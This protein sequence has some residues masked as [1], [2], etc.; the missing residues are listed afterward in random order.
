MDPNDLAGYLQQGGGAMPASTEPP[1]QDMAAVLQRMMTPDP[2][3]EA[4]MGPQR[5]P[6]YP[7]FGQ[8]I[9]RM[10]RQYDQMPEGIPGPAPTGQTPV[11][12]PYAQKP[13]Q[14]LP[15]PFRGLR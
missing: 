2:H 1:Q 15:A 7:S 6:V 11:I 8:T 12:N 10:A 13:F 5:Q 4:M 9:S 3:I 14:P